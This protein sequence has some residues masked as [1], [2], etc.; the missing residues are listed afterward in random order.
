MKGDSGVSVV[1]ELMIQEKSQKW[2]FF[3]LSKNAVGMGRVRKARIEKDT[4]S[5]S[6]S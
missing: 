4:V 3:F 6:S 1:R 2:S 5:F